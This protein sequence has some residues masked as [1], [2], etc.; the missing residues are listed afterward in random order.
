LPDP[1]IWIAAHALEQHCAVLS[2]DQDFRHIPDL[3]FRYLSPR[4]QE[5]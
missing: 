4:A 1:D 5:D 3:T 2:T